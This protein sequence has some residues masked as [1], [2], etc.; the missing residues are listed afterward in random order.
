LC[1]GVVIMKMKK[2]LLNQEVT[3]ETYLG[4]NAYGKNIAPPVVRKARIEAERKVVR[5]NLGNEVV[6]I[7]TG[8]FMPEDK[9][10]L[11]PE[12]VVT[13]DGQEFKII[14]SI[15]EFAL[16]YLSHILVYFK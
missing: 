9:D 13:Y 10:L 2:W 8:F 11:K 3:I 7:A 15:P 5:D 1:K 12:S 6:S 16:S 14:N 4:N